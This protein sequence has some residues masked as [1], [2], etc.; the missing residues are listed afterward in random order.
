MVE[1]MRSI[2]R[3]VM[4]DDAVLRTRPWG[5]TDLEIAHQALTAAGIGENEIKERRTAWI[6]AAGDAFVAD[7]TSSQN[8]IVR[9]DLSTALDQLKA[10]ETRLGLLTG[11]LREIAVAK[12]ERMGL[13]G[14]FDLTA[15]AYGE[16]AET[17]VELVPIARERAGS[18]GVPW[19]RGRTVVIGDTPG[20]IA[21]ARADRVAS[22]VFESQ[23]HP[24]AALAGADAVVSDVGG[25]LRTL[26]AWAPA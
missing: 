10:R 5:K 8:W 17:R 16:D 14:A 23:R 2:Y 18:S 25:L 19:P 6:K 9:P 20:D 11:N 15:S 7:R 3:A 13:V 21:A 24:R 4:A 1:A 26:E 22:V 12:L